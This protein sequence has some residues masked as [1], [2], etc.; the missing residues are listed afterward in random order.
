[1]DLICLVELY[2]QIIGE[3]IKEARKGGKSS[4]YDLYE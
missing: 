1:M 2:H 3:R 4:K